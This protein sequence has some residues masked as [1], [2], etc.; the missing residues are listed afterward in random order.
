MTKIPYIDEIELSDAPKG[1]TSK[2]WLK[3]AENAL[4]QP[5][6]VPVLI[7][8][9]KQPG[10]VLGLTAVV[11]GNELNGLSVIQRFFREIDA[12]KLQGTVIGIPVVN[13]PSFLMGVRRYTDQEDLNR[14]MPG[15][16]EGNSSKVYAHRIIHQIVRHFDYLI[17][18]HTA[19]FGR[20]NSY[21][22]RV[23][24]SH[25]VTAKMALLQNP[26]IIVNNDGGD[27]TLRSAATDMDIHAITV[28]VGDPSKFQKGMIRSGLTGI[29]NCLS[30]L[31]MIDDDIEEPDENPVICQRS[32]WLYTDIGG[33]LD[34][35]PQLEERVKKGEVVA[36]MRNVFGDIIKEYK[37][38]EDG[39]VVGKSVNPVSPAGGRILHL[40]IF[41]KPDHT[42]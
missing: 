33:I 9:G 42:K 41:K 32:Y 8:R 2:Y 15:K 10:P 6:C 38:P 29:F 34:V 13:V 26:Q 14:I 19:S 35:F 40:G 11:H 1:K 31:E 5:I 24:M 21:Y 27:G 36:R 28:E 17:D 37:A 30:F 22:I 25:K 3:L 20:I 18:L 39:I 23:D 4:S 16:K 7:A 12:S